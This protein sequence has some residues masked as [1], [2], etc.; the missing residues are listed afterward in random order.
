MRRTAIVLL[1]LMGLGLAAQQGLACSGMSGTAMASG[2]CD[3]DH[4]GGGGD[5]PCGPDGGPPALACSP[6]ACIAALSPAPGSAL[7][8]RQAIERT[9]SQRLDPPL[10]THLSLASP[11]EVPLDPL[12]VAWA[13]S[14]NPDLLAAAPAAYLL[15]LRLRL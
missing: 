9:E 13:D 6:A 15:T 10:F 5:G 3:G 2:C 12:S 1:L 7:Q 14:L 8:F 4:P 11:V